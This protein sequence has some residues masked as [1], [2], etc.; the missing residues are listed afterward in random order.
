M[1]NNQHGPKL[2]RVDK[3][4]TQLPPNVPFGIKSIPELAAENVQKQLNEEEKEQQ[5]RSKERTGHLL[6]E[7]EVIMR[8]N[9]VSLE[10]A[11]Q[12]FQFFIKF[13][14]EKASNEFLFK[15]TEMSRKAK[16]DLPKNRKTIKRYL[17]EVEKQI[18]KAMK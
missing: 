5:K 6:G 14:K 10:E 11:N 9:E 8:E 12:L 18:D 3:H 17:R 1:S 16:E 4:G 13:Y 7:I 15:H 2:I